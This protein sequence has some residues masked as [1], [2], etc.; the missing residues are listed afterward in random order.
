M[1]SFVLQASFEEIYYAFADGIDKFFWARL[2]K[3]VFICGKMNGTVGGQRNFVF[4]L[5][6]GFER[7]NRLEI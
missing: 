6:K 3:D 2:K 7:L 5:F 1:S 4:S